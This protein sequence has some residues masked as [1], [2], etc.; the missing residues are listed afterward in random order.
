MLN[1]KEDPSENVFK[2]H[3]EWQTGQTEV[4]EER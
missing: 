1:N 2:S 4:V 3:S